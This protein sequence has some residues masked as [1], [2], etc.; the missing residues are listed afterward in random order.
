VTHPLDPQQTPAGTAQHPVPAGSSVGEFP[1]GKVLVIRH[2]E[3]EWSASGRHTSVTD[4]P[5]TARGIEQAR[6]LAGRLA[7]RRIVRVVV[8]PR[9]RAR[10]TAELA[11]L[12]DPVVD[13]DAAEWFYGAYEGRTTEEIRR[14]RPGWTIWTGDPPGGETAAEVRTRADRLLTSIRPF[15]ADGDVAIVGHGHFGRVLTA[16]Y[17]G[18]PVPAGAHFLLGP[19]TLCTLGTEHDAPTID[20]WNLPPLTEEAP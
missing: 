3:T 17:L 10:D 4:V 8:S 12:L 7:S 15:L 20:T 13:P 6:G 5:L 16:R 19:A 18:F 11:G 9:R 1:V 2:G 14:D